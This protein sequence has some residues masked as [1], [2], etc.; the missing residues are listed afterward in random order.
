[1]TEEHPLYQRIENEYSK[2]Y[3]TS[4]L[5]P[6]LSLGKKRYAVNESIANTYELAQ[7][8]IA[9]AREQADLPDRKISDVLIALYGQLT[10]YAHELVAHRDFDSLVLLLALA[11]LESNV[12]VERSL[13]SV[14]P[15]I[16]A[17]GESIY[18]LCHDSITKDFSKP[19]DKDRAAQIINYYSIDG[20]LQKEV[21]DQD[22]ILFNRLSIWS[23]EL[24]TYQFE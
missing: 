4:E 23:D 3:P 18:Y 22:G 11:N 15:V 16:D 2:T 5:D 1:M 20:G 9:E 6:N 19:T 7:E 24:H 21:L 12:D 8:Y 17:M 13:T 14:M 10:G